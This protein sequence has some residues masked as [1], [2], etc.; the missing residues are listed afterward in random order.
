MCNI[1]TTKKTPYQFD[2][3]PVYHSYLA[4]PTLKLQP[5]EKL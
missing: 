5:K 3:N 2:V 1:S 4:Q